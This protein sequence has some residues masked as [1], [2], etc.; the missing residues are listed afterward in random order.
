M[1]E[2]SRNSDAQPADD[3]HQDPQEDI[4]ELRKLIVGPADQRLDRVQHQLDDPDQRARDISRILPR[5]VTM[6]SDRDGKLATSLAPI[7]EQAIRT[8]IKKDRQIFVDV[9]FPVMGPAIRKAIAAT[10][11]GLIQNFNQ[12]LESRL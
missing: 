1:S 6:S 2:S 7:T 5:A 4:A 10:I 9:L 8:S 11:Q 3:L 12:I